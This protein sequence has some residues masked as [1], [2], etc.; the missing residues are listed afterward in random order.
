MT[1]S[2]PATLLP[3][4][5]ASAAMARQL[6]RLSHLSEP[7]WLHGE[8]ARRLG[9][10]LQAILLQPQDWLDWGGWLGAGQ[11]VVQAR[12]PQ[13]RRWVWEPTSALAER[14]VRQWRQQNA[15]PWWARWQAV[16]PPVI[17][18]LNPPPPHWPAEGMGLVWANM[19]L[20][21]STDLDALLQTWHQTLK[22]DGFLMCSG[23]G[24]DTA[25]ELRAV[26]QTMGWGL[27]TVDFIDMH[28][29]GDAL[30]QA[31]FADPVMDMERLSLTW[32]DA[33]TML[34]EWRTWGGN[35]A[36]GRFAGCRTPRWRRQLVQ[37]LETHLKRPDGRLG[38]SLELVYG[39]AVKP[40]PRHPVT[41]E[42]RVSLDDMRR[43]IR[44]S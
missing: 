41:G 23:L 5:P 40:A 15:R 16:Q 18:H 4:A 14:S 25:K 38:L 10:K 31:G 28:D 6:S 33:E 2:S 13:A 24:P 8:V 35:V 37:A 30:V 9:D 19:A 22:V 39:H 36:A 3:M 11:V 26:Y 42:T 43:M 34:R 1:E 20:H 44:K 7:S 12:Y 32:P 21:T 29:L 17:E 27:P